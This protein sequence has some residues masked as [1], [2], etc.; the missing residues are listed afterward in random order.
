MIDSLT[1]QNIQMPKIKD[2]SIKN[3]ENFLKNNL[4][5]YTKI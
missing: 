1:K 4:L 5:D 3:N 2:V